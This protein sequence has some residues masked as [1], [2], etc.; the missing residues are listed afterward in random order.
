MISVFTCSRP[1]GFSFLLPQNE[2]L[3]HDIVRY[4]FAKWLSKW[5]F[6]YMDNKRYDFERPDFD[7]RPDLDDEKRVELEDDFYDHA[8]L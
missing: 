3:R 2:P 8:R 7:T 4:P 5:A 1:A 6:E